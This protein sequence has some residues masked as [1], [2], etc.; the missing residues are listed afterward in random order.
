MDRD[1]SFLM[2]NSDDEISENFSTVES[3]L[4]NNSRR[5]NTKSEKIV[6]NLDRIRSEKLQNALSFNAAKMI[7]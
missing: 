5:K 7:I 1:S 2:I 3:I 4:Q 6:H